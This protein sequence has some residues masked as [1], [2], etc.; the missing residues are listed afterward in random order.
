MGPEHITN[1]AL[2]TF[3]AVPEPEGWACLLKSGRG[4]T[5]CVRVATFPRTSFQFL[6]SASPTRSGL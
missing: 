4:L 5:L 6:G 2:E 3:R 1:A